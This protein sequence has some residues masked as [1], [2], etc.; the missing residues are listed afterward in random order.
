MDPEVSVEIVDT[1]VAPDA[2]LS[3]E[4]FLD[5]AIEAAQKDEPAAEEPVKEQK[6]EIAQPAEEEEKAPEKKEEPVK[7]AEPATVEPEEVTALDVEGH[8]TVKSLVE[9]MK[10][11]AFKAILDKDPG[12]RNQLFYTARHAEKA[13]K[14][15]EIFTTP[16]LAKEA[17][18]AAQEHYTFRELFEGD[19][20]LKFLEKLA[21]D[22]IARDEQG[23]FKIENGQPVSNG[24]Y[25]RAMTAYR[26]SWY[27]HIE[28]QLARFQEGALVAGDISK[29]DV[30]E[31]LNILKAVTEGKPQAK[32]ETKAPELPKEVQEQLDE[33]ARLKGE[34][35]AATDKSSGEFRSN[36]E[37]KSEELI[38]GD[39]KAVLD[40]RLPKDEAYGEYLRE[41]IINDTTANI[42]ALAKKSAPQQNV[43]NTAIRFSKRDDESLAKV[44]NMNRSYAK[45][46]LASEL[47]KVLAKA[48]KPVLAQAS[49]TASK[50][51]DQRKRVDV[52]GSAGV[53][54]PSRPDAGAIA[55]RIQSDAMKQ[56]KRLSDEQLLELTLQETTRG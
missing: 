17:Y 28:N 23:R 15:D 32:A 49:A 34:Q 21:T 47:A 5:Q 16:E 48:G 6:E 1:P 54:T 35:K 29:E 27:D 26:N 25:D 7:P 4:Q 11:Q 44:A 42:M 22:S 41:K 53:A 40:A 45:N 18:T 36:M 38:R 37:T 12:F 31:A 30:H 9:R 2:N 51:S 24:A 43:I 19:D 56:G 33:L 50:V 13:A 20:P 46:I 8:V 52:K 55:A 39:V 10:D 3:D 14:Y